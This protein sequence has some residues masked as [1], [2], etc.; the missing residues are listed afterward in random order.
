VG[1]TDYVTSDMS[2]SHVQL[3]ANLAATYGS[4]CY[5]PAVT[6]VST[7][8]PNRTKEIITVPDTSTGTSLGSSSHRYWA[9]SSWRTETCRSQMQLQLEASELAIKI[10][11]VNQ[12]HSSVT[13]TY[14][15][16]EEISSKCN[17]GLVS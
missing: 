6:G 3:R 17:E 7:Q 5:R 11:Q 1:G 12:N 9:S 14:N 10:R 4:I 13:S 15:S 2:T 8:V 16:K